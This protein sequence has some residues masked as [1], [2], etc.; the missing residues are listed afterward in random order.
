MPIGGHGR[1]EGRDETAKMR[2]SR[3]E[4]KTVRA[5]TLTFS[6]A[7]V[8]TPPMP[9]TVRAAMPSV[10]LMMALDASEPPRSCTDDMARAKATP[11]LSPERTD[12]RARR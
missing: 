6:T 2:T 11:P 1:G 5:A 12:D 8:D 9:K 10:T 3:S 4:T 7:S